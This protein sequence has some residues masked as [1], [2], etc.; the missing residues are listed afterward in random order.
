MLNEYR[1]YL[2]LILLI[3]LKNVTQT[4]EKDKYRYKDT[5]KKNRFNKKKNMTQVLN[6]SQGG[7]LCRTN[8]SKLRK[9]THDKISFE[10]YYFF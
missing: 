10:L 3:Y 4:K 5:I 8:F 2:C 9:K 6:L 7:G 1:L